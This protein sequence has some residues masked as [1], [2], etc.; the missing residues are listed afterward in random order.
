MR[1]STNEAAVSATSDCATPS[2]CRLSFTFSSITQNVTSASLT[3]FQKDITKLIVSEVART[4]CRTTNP[5]SLLFSI[6]LVVRL[7]LCRRQDY[8]SRQQ[9]RKITVQT[10]WVD[11][12]VGDGCWSLG[13][14]DDVRLLSPD[15]CCCVCRVTFARDDVLEMICS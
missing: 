10:I 3:Q 4:V 12:D 2:A 14:G 15:D 5:V 9:V 7:H 1:V 13:D 6:L 11:V 8:R